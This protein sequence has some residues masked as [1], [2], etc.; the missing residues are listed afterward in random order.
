[1]VANVD[2]IRETATALEVL[3]SAPV[4]ERVKQK[5]GTAPHVSTRVVGETNV[6]A[7]NARNTDPRAA[8]RIAD[9]YATSYVEFKQTQA[10]NEDKAAITQV[11]ATVT[12]LQRQ[13]NQISDGPQR[14]ALIAQQSA[15]K[16]TL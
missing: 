13:I 9:A 7:V 11:Q 4:Q 10:I 12:D 16:Q 3:H 6:V 2:P 5:I 1:S 14:D 15:F 8:V